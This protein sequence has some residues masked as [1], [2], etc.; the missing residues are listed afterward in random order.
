MTIKKDPAE[1]APSHR[2][3]LSDLPTANYKRL[4]FS[5]FKIHCPCGVG[6]DF[7]PLHGFTQSGK[8]YNCGKF[9]PP[10]KSRVLNRTAYSSNTSTSVSHKSV[11]NSTLGYDSEYVYIHPESDA[12]WT[13][14]VK[15]RDKVTGDKTFR[16][17]RYE[18]GNWLSGL[19]GREPILYNLKA[20]RTLQVSELVD[21][22]FVV[23]CEGEKDVET[24]LW[25]RKYCTGK[26]TLDLFPTCNPMGAGNWRDSYSK[27]MSG[28]NVLILPDYDEPGKRH[29]VSVS[30]AIVPFARTVRIIRLWDF[31]PDL[32]H[33]GDITDFLELGG[34]L[35]G[36]DE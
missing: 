17:Y 11:D 3:N 8:C 29:A 10:K 36:G 32:P 16:Q 19:N 21:H 4:P 31:M 22:C 25:H 2:V 7:V 6:N 24:I 28:L 14:V 23:I 9:F 26:V 20:I 34:M 13:K 12:P 5:K 1:V 15:Y 27:E 18:N 35:G 33:K 30:K